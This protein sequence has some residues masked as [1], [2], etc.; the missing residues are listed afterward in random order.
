MYI[1]SGLTGKTLPLSGNEDTFSDDESS[2]SEDTLDIVLL[3]EISR[4][5]V[6]RA[7]SGQRR[8][9]NPILDCDISDLERRSNGFK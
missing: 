6:R 5:G 7:I 8:H 9:S 1:N 3:H 2:T 4:I